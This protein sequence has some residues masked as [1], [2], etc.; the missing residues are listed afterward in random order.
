M[1]HSQDQIRD[2]NA[3]HLDPKVIWIWSLKSVVPSVVLMLLVVLM[4]FAFEGHILGFE[5]SEIPLWSFVFLL[6]INV[7]HM[8]WLH[9]EYKSF[10][11]YFTTSS[12]VIKK[13]VIN[14][15]R[16]VVPYE[17]IQD[18]RVSRSIIERFL[19]LAS[20]KIE[21]AAHGS[22][23]NKYVIPSVSN[24]R[25]IV[26]HMMEKTRKVVE[27]AKKEKVFDDQRAISLL[28]A[29]LAEVK[30]L[31]NVLSKKEATKTHKGK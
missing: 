13:G 23:V 2:V 30:D 4:S 6:A 19:N 21:T 1:P 31:K 12:V 18:I 28:E 26:N 29:L 10:I 22:Y 5:S 16:H 24:Y 3:F 15:E 17:R 11:Y 20:V 9:Y 25:S 8:I 7:F 14:T 27:K